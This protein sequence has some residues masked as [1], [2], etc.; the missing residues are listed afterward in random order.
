MES[1]PYY[2]VEAIGFI[3]EFLGLSET[4]FVI[5]IVFLVFAILLRYSLLAVRSDYGEVTR[6]PLW[7]RV[8]GVISGVVF[9]IFALIFMIS[10]SGN[11]W[12]AIACGVSSLGIFIIGGLINYFW[13]IV[14]PTNVTDV[15][16]DRYKVRRSRMGRPGIREPRKLD[17]R[18]SKQVNR[19]LSDNQVII[20]ILSSLS[21]IAKY[22]FVA[23][24][25][26]SV[27]S[28]YIIIR[29]Q[30]QEFYYMSLAEALRLWDILITAISSISVVVFC[31]RIFIEITAQRNEAT[32]NEI[33][34]AIKKRLAQ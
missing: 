5:S 6:A 34:I 32:G 26:I 10:R 21:V 7:K 29:I 24:A 15:G 19:K 33:V 28:N 17:E 11:V 30:M 23:Y 12:V 13:D 1:Y 3:E 25:V 31:I 14:F 8:P 9:S 2:L 4:L 22:S 16:E 27:I 20:Y 18:S